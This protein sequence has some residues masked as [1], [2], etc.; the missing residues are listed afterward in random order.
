MNNN[1]ND[2]R[3]TD[4]FAN[5]LRSAIV[6]SG[7]MAVEAIARKSGVPANDVRDYV[8]GSKIPTLSDCRSL[9]DAL[10]VPSIY[11]TRPLCEVYLSS[12]R[13]RYQLDKHRL[14]RILIDIQVAFENYYN[15]EDV[16]E[17]QP[18]DFAKEHQVSR[19]PSNADE[20][21]RVA[22]DMR[23][24]L[25]IGP[26]ELQPPVHAALDASVRLIPFSGHA[27]APNLLD[28]C[29]VKSD[30]GDKAIAFNTCAPVDRQRFTLARELG[31][32]IMG[33]ELDGA[34]VDKFA[35][36]FLMPGELVANE[37]KSRNGNGHDVESAPMGTWLALKRKFGCSIA[38]LNVRC[39]DLGLIDLQGY[40]RN[41]IRLSYLGWRKHE[42]NGGLE[43][44]QYRRYA[45]L[46]FDGWRR[47]L[48]TRS[49]LSELLGDEMDV[50]EIP[51]SG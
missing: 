27:T 31:H 43:E 5:R 7:D 42:P 6:A 33:D 16:L 50:D 9:A 34:L 26:E 46:C 28:G 44:P 15:I 29:V 35:A 38:A 19:L 10:E 36:A 17:V 49:K 3:A 45:D 25:R 41:R 18:P 47:G 30:R 1:T 40:T 37:F 8:A 51:L 21:E 14:R 24:I 11:L 2:Q 20:V 23:S 39:Y 32:L 22:G 48:I 4:P 13:K 12:N